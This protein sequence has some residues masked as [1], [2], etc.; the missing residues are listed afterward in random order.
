V[1][2]F[3]L[4]HLNQLPLVTAPFLITPDELFCGYP[5]HKQSAASFCKATFARRR[6]SMTL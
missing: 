5:S 1:S 2:A 6:K 4:S 3:F